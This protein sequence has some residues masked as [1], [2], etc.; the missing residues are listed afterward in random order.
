MDAQQILLFAL[1]GLGSGSLIA[2][3]AIGIVLTYRGSGIINLATGAVAMLMI[4][5]PRYWRTMPSAIPAMSDP[6]PSPRS[7]KSRS[8]D[9]SMR[10]ARQ[11]AEPPLRPRPGTDT[12]AA[13]PRA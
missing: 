10:Q 13:T 6:E 5:E 1:L 11:G 8:C 2:G 9:Q 4:P 12:P 7:A 3:I